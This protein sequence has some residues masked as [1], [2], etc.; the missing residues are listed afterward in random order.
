[1]RPS[2]KDPISRYLTNG[3]RGPHKPTNHVHEVSMKLVRIR[4]A[5][6]STP[7]SIAASA[8]ALSFGLAVSTC[9]EDPAKPVERIGDEDTDNHFCPPPCV[10]DGVPAPWNTVTFEIQHELSGIPGHAAG[11]QGRLVRAADGT[12]YYTYLKFA[13]HEATCDIAVFGGGPAPGVNYWLVTAVRAAG[14]T[15]W[16]EEDVPL[17]DVSGG[18]PYVTSQ[19]GVDAT[20]TSAGNL[21]VVVAGGGSGLAACG[22][23]DLVVA[24]RTPAGAWSFNVPSTASGDCCNLRDAA[25]C[26]PDFCELDY[27][28]DVNCTSGTD[29]GAWA[30]VALSE[31]GTTGVAFSDYH[32]FW[33]Q[34]GQNHIGLEFWGS[35]GVSGIRPWSGKGLYAALVFSGETPLVAFTGY[36]DG[37]M[38]ILRRATNNGDG[39]DWVEPMAGANP[40]SN[41]WTGYD[42]G[43][44]IRM[45]RAPDGTL[46][47][48]FHARKN[49]NSELIN[50]LLYCSS[51]D[52]GETWS[53]PC[54][55][56]GIDQH[57]GFYPSLAYDNAN[58]PYVAYRTCGADSQCGVGSDGTKMAWYDKGASRW[59]TF[60]VHGS[61]DSVSGHHSQLV[62]D[63]GTKEP[64]IVFQNL[65]RGT[66]VV[67][68]GKFE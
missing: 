43:E 24:T 52:G 41:Y 19:F 37:G 13:Y 58:I 53:F 9:K 20:V 1:V 62:V 65:T 68:Q 30:A 61:A 56:I 40:W 55:R 64:T 21:V 39:N 6:R 8:L 42:I 14:G 27:C 23:G 26:A 31:A 2:D 15:E 54:K 35:G 29:V 22:S 32:N 48:V 28:L 38:S 34:D 46:G 33:D 49:R 59:W 25:T 7:V 5:T 18:L 36:K 12:L 63:P 44:R 47:V 4:S 16:T 66:A 67:V 51:D 57:E 3:S 17:E 10:E 45:A 60:S 50:D 11:T